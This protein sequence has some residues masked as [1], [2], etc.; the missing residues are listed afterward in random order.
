MRANCVWLA[1]TSDL[2]HLSVWECEYNF[3][4]NGALLKVWYFLFSLIWI[5]FPLLIWTY[6]SLLIWGT[7]VGRFLY[8]D[9]PSRPNSY[10]KIITW[11]EIFLQ[12]KYALEVSYCGTI[13]IWFRA[14]LQFW[15]FAEIYLILCSC[16][17]YFILILL[18]VKP[19]P[20]SCFA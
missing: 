13:F 11:M 6:F 15:P 14:N 2:L 18:F 17:L 20:L 8:R 4:I 7:S 12:G 16:E 1:Q 19:F 9:F 5:C 10:K 3:N